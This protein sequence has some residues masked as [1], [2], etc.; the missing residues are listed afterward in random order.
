MK[1]YNNIGSIVFTEGF[2]IV[3]TNPYKM[4]DKTKIRKLFIYY[5]LEFIIFIFHLNMLL[6]RIL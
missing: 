5:F 6:N 1:D 2:T 3:D 4:A